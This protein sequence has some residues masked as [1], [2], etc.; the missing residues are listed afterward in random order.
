[1]T[2]IQK[3]NLKQENKSKHNKT[4]N[5]PDEL[6]HT[7]IEPRAVIMERHCHYFTYLDRTQ[8]S[9]YGKTPSLLYIPG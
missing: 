9:T 8:G 7:W 4:K 6:A 3:V 2:L 1:M 5:N